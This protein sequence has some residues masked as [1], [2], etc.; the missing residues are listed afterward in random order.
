MYTG[1]R[2]LV[3]LNP[4]D[5][6]PY[7]AFVPEALAHIRN[8]PPSPGRIARDR[9]RFDLKHRELKPFANPLAKGYGGDKNTPWP[10]D[11]N[12]ALVDGRYRAGI[13][14]AINADW[15]ASNWKYYA[16]LMLMEVLEELIAE[17][18]DE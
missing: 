13:R 11:R 1:K 14:N 2:V 9:E 5:E 12:R 16:R 10:F 15:P 8:R 18:E 3:D 4:P 6:E 17:E 7:W